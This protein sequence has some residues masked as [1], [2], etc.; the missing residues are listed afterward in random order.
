MKITEDSLRVLS[1]TII[2]INIYQPRPLYLA[3]S[4]FRIEGE[5]K[6][7]PYKQKLKEFSTTRQAL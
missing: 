7:F 3:K 5:I 2:Q 6:S 1:D 4:S